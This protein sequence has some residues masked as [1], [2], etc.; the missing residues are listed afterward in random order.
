[1]GK[2]ELNLLIINTISIVRKGVLASEATP[3]TDCNFAEQFN[4]QKDEDKVILSDF[5][6]VF[7]V[8]LLFRESGTPD[9]YYCI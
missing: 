7:S 4:H 8:M 9:Y 5:D 1:M 2:N 3:G 6:A